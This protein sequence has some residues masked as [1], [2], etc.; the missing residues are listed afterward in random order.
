M[1]ILD[2]IRKAWNAFRNNQIEYA[3]VSYASGA[4]SYGTSPSRPTLRVYNERS[5]ISSIYTR[6][7]IDVAGI[8][9]RHVKV[10]D[11]GRYSEDV[12]DPLNDC[13]TYE[14]N[15]DQSPRA[16][17]QD[18]AMTLFDRGVC[19]VVPVD[20][21]VKPVNG[22]QFDIYTMRVGEILVW[23]PNHVRVNV[24][25]EKTGKRE[26]LVLEKS[27]VAIIENP[28]Y[29]VM[30][31]PNS[32]LQRLIRKLGLLDI[33]DEQSSSGKLDIIIQLPY[34]IKSESRRA[35]AEQRRE[36]IEF[37]LK[38]SQYGIA[39][40]DGTEK[41]TQLNRPAE[42]NLMNQI[43]YLVKLL[44]TQ[45]G[46][47]DEV[48][49][50]TANE[51]AM[52]NYF[53]RTIEPI[54][55]AI[56]ESMQRAFLG[57]QGTQN[58]ERIMY[59]RDPFKYVP[60]NQIADI[61]DKFIRNEILTSNE[62]RSIMGVKPSKDPNA[63]KLINPNMPLEKTHPENVGVPGPNSFERNSQN[64]SGLQRIRN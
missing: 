59:F 25:N 29:A 1:P 16:F 31:E 56:V 2:R 15:L 49:N 33:V 6:I 48:M 38:G 10:D 54:I 5:L 63:D 44:Y 23:Y 60:L 27:Y 24:Y 19:A 26:E 4:P 62:I 21:S 3:D 7:A 37:Q 61:A 32:T 45:L 9:V 11:E 40:I 50:G 34:V 30:N 42:N 47:T 39:Y 52:L 51:A 64:G 22:N 18:I 46:I 55:V 43:E 20:T 28:L 8:A 14:A 13:L 12:E 36:D 41:I 17:R 57:P 35:A 53:N 58:D